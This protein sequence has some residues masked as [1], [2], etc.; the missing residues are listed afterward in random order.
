MGREQQRVGRDGKDVATCPGRGGDGEVLYYILQETLRE[1]GQAEWALQVARQ[2]VRQYPESAELLCR[3]FVV[4]VQVCDWRGWPAFT[5]QLQSFLG[6]GDGEDGGGG[7][8]FGR[9]RNLNCITA[10]DSLY[11]PV[12]AE[13]VKRIAQGHAHD[14]ERLLG[15]EGV[16]HRQEF[17]RRWLDAMKG[18]DAQG[19]GG[20][21]LMPLPA[22]LSGQ[23][24]GPRARGL[25]VG[26]LSSHLNHW[27][28]GRDMLHVL[29]L[30]RRQRVESV[31]MSLSRAEKGPAVVWQRQI[32]EACDTWVDVSRLADTALAREINS[33]SVHV[34]V[35]LNGWIT[36]H[37]NAATALRPAPVQIIFKDFP[38]TFGGGAGIISH[39]LSDRVV[40]P[41]DLE[42][43]YAEALVLVPPS[44]HANAHSFLHAPFVGR[45]E[46]GGN[47]QRLREELT[48]WGIP[49]HGTLLCNFN[50]L[51]K[52]DPVTFDSW[53]QVLLR[54]NGPEV[55]RRDG[56]AETDLCYLWL[57]KWSRL[58]VDNLR[59]YVRASAR[60][61]HLESFLIFTE[62]LPESDHVRLKG[63]ADLFLDTPRYNAHGTM[64]DN[65]WARVPAVSLPQQ[66]LASR[67]TASLLTAA[68][69]A[70]ACLV[71]THSDYVAVAGRAV[72]GEVGVA[73]R[74]HISSHL[75]PAAPRWGAAAVE[76]AGA[77][78]GRSVR[79][80]ED[81]GGHAQS[82]GGRAKAEEGAQGQKA[83]GNDRGPQ[84]KNEA[85]DLSRTVESLEVAYAL[86][87]E[88]CLHRETSGKEFQ[89][90]GEGEA[91]LEGGGAAHIVVT[92][93]SV[94]V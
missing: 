28:L 36:G 55:G 16:L 94:H 87:W 91:Q 72:R 92:L 93:P 12:S 73:W 89:R 46:D 15:T 80:V 75:V 14:L 13:A 26:Y 18:G 37:R 23:S 5:L 34:L 66:T 63:G 59:R 82:G 27:A 84:G 20:A 54:C 51:Y 29:R 9:V 48:A 21:W 65:I 24:A 60:Y 35:N 67:V 50:S 76:W 61:A 44:Y 90:V 39:V 56:R 79:G 64:A 57:L 45:V 30:H 31:C 33:H 47:K 7:Q 81:R 19:I 49:R 40:T 41:P 88:E 43:L 38:G 25:K 6:Y 70:G 17:R 52:I 86:L 2:G 1:A 4:A 62:L 11:M 22:S 68:G 10:W 78:V 85:F 42:C 58:A 53:L 69:T 71:R 83:M 32:R 74:R 3:M 77:V 8:L